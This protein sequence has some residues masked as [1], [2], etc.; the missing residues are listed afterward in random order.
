[1][2]N[3]KFGFSQMAERTP[4]VISKI[5]RALNFFSGGV[6]AFLPQIAQ[7]LHTTTDKLAGIM[8]IV[9][10]VVNTVGIMFGVQPEQKLPYNETPNQ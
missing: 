4:L 8:G 9:I 10:L 3:V 5:K 7:D 2:E 1:M 6:V